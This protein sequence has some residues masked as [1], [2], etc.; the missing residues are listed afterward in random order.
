ME[1][2][3]LARR[4]ELQFPLLDPTNYSVTSDA[5]DEYNCVGWA[6]N[7]IDPG[8]WWP[9]PD[10]PEYFWPPGA[11]R[12]ETLE[13]F[14]EGFGAIGF[15]VCEDGDLEPGI[16][17]VAVYATRGVPTHVA[18]QLANGRWT[19]KLGEWE[20]IEH[21]TLRDL[22]GGIYGQPALFLSRPIAARSTAD[23]GEP[24]DRI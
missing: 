18:R 11:R 8:Q 23:H 24:E 22:S 1:P 3:R 10:A 15:R 13:A 2:R 5:T 9:L 12:D 14:I 4:R 21:A 20:D 17:K 19:S 16:E 6:A 7:E